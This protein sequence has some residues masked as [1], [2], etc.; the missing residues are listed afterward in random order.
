MKLIPTSGVMLNS[1]AYISTT[2]ALC[3]ES[4]EQPMKQETK[5]CPAAV[6]IRPA[7]WERT[8]IDRFRA[9]PAAN[10]IT[11]RFLMSLAS[12]QGRTHSAALPV[13]CSMS[14]M[15]CGPHHS[16][17]A[18]QKPHTKRLFGMRKSQLLIILI[19]FAALFLI[20]QSFT[21]SSSLRRYL[22][23]LPW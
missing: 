20:N 17:P 15:S 7:T 22:G 21:E 11:H 19:L 5:F 3:R 2:S 18:G 9:P 16:G 4:T 10:V 6:V 1:T 13:M 14:K 8:S 23:G 12:N